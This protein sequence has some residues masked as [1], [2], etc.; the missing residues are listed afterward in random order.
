ML[1]L[2]E[3]NGL[4]IKLRNIE[5]KLDLIMKELNIKDPEAVFQV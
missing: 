1:K 3:I 5:R 2:N 4:G